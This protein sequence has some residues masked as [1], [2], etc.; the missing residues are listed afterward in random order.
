MTTKIITT[1][2]KIVT[3]A[4]TTTTIITKATITTKITRKIIDG[5]IRIYKK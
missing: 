5:G 2:T 3:K 4:K 1:A